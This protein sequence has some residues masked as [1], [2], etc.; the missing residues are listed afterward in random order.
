MQSPKEIIHLKYYGMYNSVKLLQQKMFTKTFPNTKILYASQ[1]SDIPGFWCDL[2]KEAQNNKAIINLIGVSKNTQLK[3]IK[4]TDLNDIWNN[5][6]ILINSE[7]LQIV[8]NAKELTISNNIISK[9]IGINFIIRHKLK[10]ILN[11]TSFVMFLLRVQF[12][13]IRKSDENSTIDRIFNPTGKSQKKLSPSRS[14][15]EL[16]YYEIYSLMWH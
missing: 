3:K 4:Y 2:I 12:L 13:H 14:I 7:K 10:E 8:S 1:I 5:V 9:D 6:N 16:K 15:F 11:I